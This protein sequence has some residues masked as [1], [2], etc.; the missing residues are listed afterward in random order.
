MW[1]QQDEATA[2]AVRSTIQLLNDVSPQR[3][4]SRS[5][6]LAWA[7]RYPDLTAPDFFLWVF[8]KSKVYVNKPQTT[9]HLKDNIHEIEEIQPQID[10]G[11]HLADIIFQ[12]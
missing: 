11:H 3:L 5:G 12:L 2:H 7:V 1:F 8:L 9:Q 10:R 4:I 6:E